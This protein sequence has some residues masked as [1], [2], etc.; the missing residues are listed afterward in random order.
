MPIGDVGRKR[1]NR[2]LKNR[3]FAKFGFTNPYPW[4]SDAEAMVHLELE[5]RQVPFSWRYF[6]GDSP[7]RMLYMPDFHP[8]FTLREYNV[9][10]CVIGAFFG[11]M[12]GVLDRVA[13]GQTVLEADGWKVHVWQEFEITAGVRDLFRRDLPQLEKPAVTGPLRPNPYGIPT[14]MAERR[15]RLSGLALLNKQFKFDKQESESATRR[16]RR[17][18]RGFRTRDGGRRRITRE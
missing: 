16:R 1:F 17:V 11:D 14:H 8:E 3:V 4:M 2:L 12:P 5:A 13:L 15:Q 10:I 18:R 7:S 6:D 9:A